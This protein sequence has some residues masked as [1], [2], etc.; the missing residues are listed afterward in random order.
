MEQNKKY[1]CYDYRQERQLLGLRMRLQD[2]NLTEKEQQQI[3]SDIKALEAE[4]G[5]A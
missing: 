4:I 2:V 5:I 3:K 1:T